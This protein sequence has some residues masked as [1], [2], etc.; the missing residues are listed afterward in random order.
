MAIENAAGGDS[1]KTFKIEPSVEARVRQDA[2][3]LSAL[4]TGE[5][6]DAKIFNDPGLNSVL[7]KLVIDSAKGSEPKAGVDAQAPASQTKDAADFAA[8]QR[9]AYKKELDQL[10]DQAGKSD[11]VQKG[12]GYYQ[13]LQRMFPDMKHDQLRNLALE[14]RTV[15][16]NNHV[17]HRGQKFEMLSPQQK[18]TLENNIMN[19]YDRAHGKSDLKD[20]AIDPVIQRVAKAIGAMVEKELESDLKKSLEPVKTA[21]KVEKPEPDP[22]TDPAEKPPV[23]DKTDDKLVPMEMRVKLAEAACSRTYDQVEKSAKLAKFVSEQFAPDSESYK[24]AMDKLTNAIK[25]ERTALS[26]LEQLAKENPQD[27]KLGE[28]CEANYKAFMKQ[29]MRVLKQLHDP[30]L[31]SGNGKPTERSIQDPYLYNAPSQA[32]LEDQKNA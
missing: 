14:T 24:W 1:S 12:E 2:P 15:N 13:V 31:I 28:D 11:K 27:Q 26:N 5:K 19:D 25:E 16:G 4:M 22:K 3:L 17:L 32:A 7:G 6:Q 10:L 18:S 20:V 8:K 29:Q 23:A 30:S 9:D 21:E